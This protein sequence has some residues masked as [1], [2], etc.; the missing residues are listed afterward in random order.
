MYISREI[1]VWAAVKFNRFCVRVS[2]S[3]YI[4]TDNRQVPIDHG[5]LIKML[6]L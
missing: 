1:L 5:S 6:S 2:V 4:P 3:Q